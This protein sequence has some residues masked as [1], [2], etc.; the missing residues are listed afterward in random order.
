MTETI[1]VE[2]LRSRVGGR[3]IG[4]SMVLDTNPARPTEVVAEVEFVG[5]EVA[6]E[7]VAAARAAALHWRSLPA[8][9][10]GEILRLAAEHLEDSIEGVAKTLSREEGKTL[11][12]ATGEVRRAIGVLRYYAA[13]TLEP[14]GETYGS[15]SP[16]TFLYA[17]REPIGTVLVITP[18]NFPISIAAWKI[19]PALA[20]G[21]TVVWKPS[22]LTPATAVRLWEAFSAAGLLDGVLN[23]VL[24]RGSDVGEALLTAGVDGVSFTGSN[25]VGLSVQTTAIAA[26]ARVQL[27]L[28][29][30]NPAIVLAD[31]DL[32]L[33]VREVVKGAFMGTGQKCTAT[34]RVIVERPIATEFKRELADAAQELTVGDPLAPTTDLGPLVSASATEKVRQYLDIAREDGGLVLAGGGMPDIDEGYFFNPTVIDGLDGSSRVLRDEIFGPVAAILEVDDFDAALRAAN[35]TPFG[36]SASLF[37]TDLRKALAFAREIRAGVV[38]VNLE[39]GGGDFHVPFGGMKSSSSG[40]REQGKAAREF[41]TE[42]KTVYIDTPDVQGS[43]TPETSRARA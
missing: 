42:W 26:G 13:Q 14:D 16:S 31:A 40:S 25:A 3:A 1:G 38:R 15:S 4:G 9:S 23:L 36:L 39:T 7:A 11:P 32:D 27:E 35:D 20:F 30:K 34:S 12:E 43:G 37:T 28:G 29:G 19:A 17:R 2:R 5:P 21:N 41:F 6:R 33:A 18:W 8:P 10:R 24:G 22:E